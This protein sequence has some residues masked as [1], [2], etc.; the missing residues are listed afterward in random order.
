LIYSIIVIL[1]FGFAT[2]N[3]SALKANNDYIATPNNYAL[4]YQEYEAITSDSLT[5]K[6]W[7][8]PAQDAMPNDSVSHY[9]QN[10]NKKRKYITDGNAKPTIVVCNGDAGNMSYLISY[11][12]QFCTNGFNVVTFDWRGYGKSSY[13]PIDTNYVIIDEFFADYDAVINRLN[14]ISEV[15]NNNIG[16]FGFS[17]GA[18][19]SYA[20]AYKHKSIKAVVTRG[21][22]CDYKSTVKR[23][24]ENKPNDT[25]L[26]PEEIDRYSPKNTYKDFEKPIFLIVGENDKVTPVIESK[27][28]LCNVKSSVREIWIVESAGHGGAEAPEY[29]EQELF[30]KKAI[31]F[32]NEN[33]NN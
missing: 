33:L 9:F 2:I 3:L 6:I 21:L 13:F 30:F 5:I 14:S 32:F 22:F 16:V 26:Y 1:F 7:F 15:D 18:F 10:K 8:Y 19:F 4:M 12:Y 24:I 11:A 17:T 20:M 29:V 27:E 23:L 25:Y 28:V 31:R